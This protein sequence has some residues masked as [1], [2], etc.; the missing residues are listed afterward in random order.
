ME[1]C[2]PCGFEGDATPIQQAIGAVTQFPR[3]VL[4]LLDDVSSD[5][6][7]RQPSPQVWSAL[8]YAAHTGETV[9]WYRH[10]IERVLTEERPQLLPLDW[11][12]ACEQGRYRERP[13]AT[14]LRAIESNCAGLEIRAREMEPSQWDRCG[15]GSDGSPRSAALLVRRAAHEAVHHAQDIRDVLN[16]VRRA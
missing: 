14:V 10:R 9:A 8:E 4:E 15:I 12:K 11:D 1:R 7:R 6:V 5:V 3:L 13:L 16:Q 2:R